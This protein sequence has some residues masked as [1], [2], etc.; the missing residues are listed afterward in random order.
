[1][2]NEIRQTPVAVQKPAEVPVEQAQPQ[3]EPVGKP[4]TPPGLDKAKQADAAQQQQQLKQE[5]V[6][7]QAQDFFAV[8]ESIFEEGMEAK[9]PQGSQG[10]EISADAEGKE[11]FR[12]MALVREFFRKAGDMLQHQKMGV[13]Q[14]LKFLKTEQGGAFWEKVQRILQQGAT[15]GSLLQAQKSGKEEGRQARIQIALSEVGRPSEGEGGAGD[16]VKR[17]AGRAMLEMIQ[18]EI[19]PKGQMEHMVLALQILAR[20]NLEESQKKLTSYLRNRWEMNEE[21][22]DRFLGKFPIAYF[23]GPM[24]LEKEK[25]AAN[26]W[27][28]FIAV[29]VVPIAM[30]L[31]L[32]FVE[33]IILAVVM[34]VI[35]AIISAYLQK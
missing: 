23:Q 20:Q 4:E 22:M 8:L 1:M 31:G 15:G 35:A 6:K 7:R 10:A 30:S 28:V 16:S 11:F 13:D 18:A 12:E 21:E 19:N 3:G 34:A 9:V 29:A 14:L 25:K 27:Y 5:D 24:P 26:F 33:A 17:D 32:K 2:S